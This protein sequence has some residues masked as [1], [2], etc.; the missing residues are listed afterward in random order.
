MR[1]P[2]NTE[3]RPTP[4]D[5][6]VTMSVEGTSSLVAIEWAILA[7]DHEV[8]QKF[9]PNVAA[10]RLFQESA[11]SEQRKVH[12]RQL[13]LTRVKEQ[14]SMLSDLARKSAETYHRVTVERNGLTTEL[15]EKN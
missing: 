9:S 12:A 3:A 14:A 5:D 2:I 15:R 4:E 11:K 7:K 10:S 13:D 1:E 6:Q 8:L